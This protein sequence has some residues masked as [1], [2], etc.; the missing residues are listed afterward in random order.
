[1][2]FES[3]RVELQSEDFS[4]SDVN[5]TIQ[6]LPH[7]HVDPNYPPNY[8][9]TKGSLCYRF[10]DGGH[11]IELEVT[12]YK[13]ISCRFTLCHPTTI[14]DVFLA[15]IRELMSQ[16]KMTVRMCDGVLPEHIREFTLD[17][18]QDFTGIVRHFI[19]KNRSGWIGMFGAETIVAS[20]REVYEKVILPLCV[21]YNR[22]SSIPTS[23]LS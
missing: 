3:F 4:A 21:P 1:M 22:E 2:G 16:L 11:V 15:L 14:D 8:P 19:A 6:N 7:I 23:N 9:L 10:D 12:N 13:I 20:T 5:R 18:F 17:E